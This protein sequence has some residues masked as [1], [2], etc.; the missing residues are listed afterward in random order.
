MSDST[1]KHPKIANLGDKAGTNNFSKKQPTPEQKKAGWDKK[2]KGAE[3][4]KHILEQKFTGAKDGQLKAEI[5]MYFNCP[6]SEITVEMAMIFRQAQKALSK[7]D[8]PAF[9]AV[10]ERGYG[11]PKQEIEHS[12]VKFKVTAT[13]K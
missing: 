12:G 10:I 7:A 6:E 2:K 11:Q 8:T 5:A 1:K 4:V 9:K 13:K 3:L